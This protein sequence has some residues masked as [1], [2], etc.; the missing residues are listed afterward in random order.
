MKLLILQTHSHDHPLAQDSYGVIS[1]AA[2]L[3][4][5]VT[6]VLCAEGISHLSQPDL[7]SH[8]H[9]AFDFGLKKI[10]VIE[11]PSGADLSKSEDVQ[12]ERAS[13]ADLGNLIEI[14]DKVLT[15]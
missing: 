3:D 10:Y 1:T 6:L 7:V 8:L 14:H 15:F 5:E 13:A 9:S 12:F 4:L 11:G 2:M